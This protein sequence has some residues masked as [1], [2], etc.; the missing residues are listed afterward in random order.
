FEGPHALC[1]ALDIDG[2]RPRPVA[3]TPTYHP[4]Q[5]K[6]PKSSTPVTFGQRPKPTGRIICFSPASGAESIVRRKPTTKRT[7]DHDRTRS[8]S[9]SVQILLRRIPPERASQVL[10]VLRKDERLL[11][12]DGRHQ[13]R[14][15][16]HEA[17]RHHAQ[18]RC[19][20]GPPVRKA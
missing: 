4:P 3:V 15:V 12:V 13:D 19:S 14:R 18:P 1:F 10:P 6:P 7:N 2:C 17:L 9:R 16:R 20:A 5:P 8:K 11:H